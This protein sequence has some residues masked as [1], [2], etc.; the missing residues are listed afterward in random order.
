MNKT[1]IFAAILLAAAVLAH[2]AVETD[3]QDNATSLA[4]SFPAASTAPVPPENTNL[5][6]RFSCLL[7]NEVVAFLIAAGAF[8]TAGVCAVDQ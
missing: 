4:G 8:G 5:S 2:A 3:R 7:P 6:A 1:P